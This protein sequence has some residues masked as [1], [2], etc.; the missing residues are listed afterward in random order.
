MLVGLISIRRL[1]QADSNGC[2]NVRDKVLLNMHQSYIIRINRLRTHKA[3]KTHTQWIRMQWSSVVIRIIIVVVV[4]TIITITIIS[5]IIF[6]IIYFLVLK[7][8][9]FTHICDSLCPNLTGPPASMLLKCRKGHRYRWST[10][11]KSHD[12]SELILGLRP[13]N[14]RRR[15]KVISSLIGWAQT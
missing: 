15:Y 14:K 1:N 6:I 10:I 3:T 2:H 4:V 7:H 9:S 5:T 13:A 12:S 8:G 11:T